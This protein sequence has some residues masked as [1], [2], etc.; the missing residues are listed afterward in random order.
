MG[1]LPRSHDALGSSSLSFAGM[2]A[3]CLR[4]AEDHK[5]D[6]GPRL[7]SMLQ[8]RC[9]DWTD[10]PGENDYGCVE[11]KWRL[12]PEHS[13]RRARNLA[14]QMRFRLGE[15]NGTAY[16]LL[17]V[18]DSG[19]PLGLSPK[20]HVDAVRVL[21]GVATDAG[22]ALRL[23]ALSDTGKS[24][25]LCSAWRVGAKDQAVAQVADSLHVTQFK[26]NPNE[27]CAASSPRSTQLRSGEV[28]ARAKSWPS[29]E[30]STE[31]VST[32]SARRRTCSCG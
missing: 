27:V 29:S 6:F 16:Y 5:A 23:E 9:L 32:G 8:N 13:Q 12:G 22:G 14:T 31:A 20:E 18:R 25:K 24:G 11:Y 21:M 17:G 10:L 30:R 26:A 15:G 2:E 28:K 3:F 19:T 1:V 4:T 7:Q